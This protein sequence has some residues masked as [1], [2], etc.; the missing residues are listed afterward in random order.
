MGVV[1]KKQESVG[2]EKK[3]PKNRVKKKLE[4]TSITKNNQ[5][6]DMFHHT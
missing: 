3:E 5:Q 4:A 2:W 1:D 6:I